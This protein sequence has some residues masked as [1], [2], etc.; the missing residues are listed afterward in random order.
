MKNKIIE[1]LAKPSVYASGG[2]RV[3]GSGGDSSQ[4]PGFLNPDSRRL[5]G[6]A[7]ASIGMTL[8]VCSVVLSGC[9]PK[10]QGPPPGASAVPVRTATA[11]IEPVEDLISVVATVAAREAVDIKAEMDGRV[12]TIGFEE[13]AA[14]TN[15]Q[16]LFQLDQGKAA[17]ALAQAQ[18]S[19]ALAQAN[20]TRNRALFDSN[21]ISKQELEQ[22]QAAF[23][24]NG[25]TVDLM[26]ER[27]KDSIIQAPFDG[28]MGARHVSPGQVI[29]QNTLLTTIVSIDPVKIEFRVPERYLGKLRLGQALALKIQAYPAE[30]FRGAVFFVGP[31]VD[32]STR[33]VLMKATIPNPDGRLRPGMFGTLDLILQT[34]DQAVVVPEN[35]IQLQGDQTFVWI[36][37][38]ENRSQMRPVTVGVRLPG[39]AEIQQG[40]Q[41]GETVVVEGLQKLRP[42]GPVTAKLVA[43][44]PDATRATNAKRGAASL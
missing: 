36:V 14:V 6:F 16:I 25:A 2:F 27:F 11:A 44:R 3:R 41:S 21:T 13:G 4:N 17:A 7:S 26:R 32:P 19:F 29:S 18:A 30:S 12:E 10:E 9:T 39:K 28:V 23:E 1:S 31:R 22:A 40:L 43:E 15:R 8:L 38:A 42:G 35:A 33:T 24:L 37:D 34:R 20:A 5:Q